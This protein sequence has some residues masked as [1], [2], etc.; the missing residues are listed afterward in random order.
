M[1]EFQT[2]AEPS[3]KKAVADAELTPREM[4][5]LQL[6]APAVPIKR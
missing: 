5:V 3:R 6:V 2:Q 1:K 4:E